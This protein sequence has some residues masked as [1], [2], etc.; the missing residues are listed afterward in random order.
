MKELED[1]WEWFEKSGVANAII[2]K[3]LKDPE[4]KEKAASEIKEKGERLREVSRELHDELPLAHYQ[5]LNAPPQ[6]LDK[7]NIGPKG[8]D[9]IEADR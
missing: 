8:I 6:I 7:L 3:Y 2:A 9:N 5:Y 4:W 1:L